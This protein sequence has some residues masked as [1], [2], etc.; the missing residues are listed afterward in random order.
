MCKNIYCMDIGKIEYLKLL[1]SLLK[2]FQHNFKI[3]KGVEGNSGN[4]KVIGCDI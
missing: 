4:G 3:V 1:L 2:S